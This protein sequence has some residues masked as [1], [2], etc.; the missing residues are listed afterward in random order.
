M[1]LENTDPAV[2]ENLVQYLYLGQT[3]LTKQRMEQLKTLCQ[4]LRLNVKLDFESE[5]DD[6]VGGSIDEIKP[7]PRGRRSLLPK[8]GSLPSG[9]SGRTGGKRVK[10]E[11]NNEFTLLKRS[12]LKDASTFTRRRPA[13]RK[14]VCGSPNNRSK[15]KTEPDTCERTVKSAPKPQSKRKRRKRDA[16]ELEQG[17]IDGRSDGEGGKLHEEAKKRKWRIS[18][19]DISKSEDNT[20]K[21]WLKKESEGVDSDTA[22][23]S[24]NAQNQ[25]DG[26]LASKQPERI[27]ADPDPNPNPDTETS[28]QLPSSAEGQAQKHQ[29]K[30]EPLTQASDDSPQTEKSPKSPVK[31]I[32]KAPSNKGSDNEE[33]DTAKKTQTPKA[34]VQVAS[35]KK[36]DLFASEDIVFCN[37]CN[38]I[39][40]SKAA[41]EKHNRQV[42][43][44]QAEDED[45]EDESDDKNVEEDLKKTGDKKKTKAKIRQERRTSL[46]S[47]EGSSESDGGDSDEDALDADSKR[48]S[49]KKRVLGLSPVKELE[50]D[51]EDMAC[52][53][54]ETSFDKSSSLRNHVLNHFKDQ[55][56]N[57]LPKS[58]P[59]ICPKC[60]QTSRDKITLM[61][62]YAF[63]HR[64]IFDY[65]SEQ[66][67]GKGLDS[68]KKRELLSK[69]KDS[70]P[71]KSFGESELT[72]ESL[73]I[74][75]KQTDQE[76]VHLHANFSDDSDEGLAF[77]SETMKSLNN[78]R[79]EDERHGDKNSMYRDNSSGDEIGLKKEL[80]ECTTATMFDII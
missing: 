72:E 33:N 7:K 69:R 28:D 70:S 27:N 15:K 39:L 55:L 14:N 56:C 65:C 2:V 4:R 47:K 23:N 66:D 24:D 43:G 17:V 13:K 78:G 75:E 40:V 57:D 12:T 37:D 16:S 20:V 26:E 6:S 34:Q 64:I 19:C 74:P 77:V 61:R 62:H 3:T 38:A 51:K 46:R 42:H 67:L 1:S 54:C 79:S 10:P 63:S 22:G 29:N 11:H 35:F 18:L 68:V 30:C 45:A 50:G 52:R 76:A 21:K 31:E 73:S 9:A 44:E 32:D 80:R 36:R 53:F 71:E 25:E 5:R 49:G 58:K 48:R 8:Q 60:D 59:F 41:F